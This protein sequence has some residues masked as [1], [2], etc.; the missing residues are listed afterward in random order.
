VRHLTAGPCGMVHASRSL[1]LLSAGMP[2]RSL[3]RTDLHRTMNDIEV[4]GTL[5]QDVERRRASSVMGRDYPLASSYYSTMLELREEHEQ[6]TKAA[7]RQRQADERQ[8]L[9][10]AFAHLDHDLTVEWTQRMDEFEVKCQDMWKNLAQRHVVARE[11]LKKACEPLMRLTPKFS[12]EL[13]AMMR[14]EVV[15]AKQHAYAQAAEVR[16]RVEI[17]KGVELKDFNDARE[18]RIKLRYDRLDAAQE[19]DRKELHARI[20]GM[21]TTI[22][23]KREL[24][25]RTQGQRRTNNGY[26]MSH[27]HKIEYS[28]IQARVPG[29][30]VRPRKSFMTKSSTFKGTHIC[31]AMAKTHTPGSWGGVLAV[32]EMQESASKEDNDRLMRPVGFGH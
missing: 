7:E 15:L 21:K 11:E 19:E 2:A 1:P 10:D 18:S 14:A 31:R 23:R 28:D 16:R 4:G 6:E 26:D 27:A 30:A 13:L 32:V 12:P 29:L 5:I 3:S 24:A 22:K 17:R 8:R 9:D 25:R 20:H